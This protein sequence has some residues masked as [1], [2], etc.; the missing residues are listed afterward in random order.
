[1]EPT[2]D[3]A[4]YPS[5]TRQR[6]PRKPPGPGRG[7][8]ACD[9]QRP[10][11]LAAPLWR[12]PGS[13]NVAPGAP[14]APRHGGPSVAG[15][16]PVTDGPEASWALAWCRAGVTGCPGMAS[17]EASPTPPPAVSHRARCPCQAGPRPAP[18]PPGARPRGR[19]VHARSTKAGRLDSYA[20]R[21]LLTHM[22]PS[23]RSQAE[24]QSRDPMRLCEQ[25]SRTGGARSAGVGDRTWRG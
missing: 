19:L 12:E 14:P 2:A 13:K 25:A 5:W 24:R 16:L 20:R 11:A 9:D 10:A 7:R 21:L 17:A 3:R 4:P 22:T 23:E 6:G 18:Q 8:A 1:M 15:G